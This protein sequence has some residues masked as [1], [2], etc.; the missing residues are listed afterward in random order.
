MKTLKHTVLAL[1][2]VSSMGGLALA[3]EAKKEVGK[4]EGQ[5]N[6]GGVSGSFRAF[7]L[8]LAEVMISDTQSKLSK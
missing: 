1:L 6:I 4:G 2:A 8:C 3:Q 7:S 5:V